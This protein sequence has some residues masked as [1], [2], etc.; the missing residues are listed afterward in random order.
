MVVLYVVART[1]R[2]VTVQKQLLLGRGYEP[3]LIRTEP[4]DR[5]RAG[6]PR[7]PIP[8]LS[9]RSRRNPWYHPAVLAAVDRYLSCDT[10]SKHKKLAI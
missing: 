8:Y 3:V 6:R 4:V 10:Q 1:L 5:E 9:L 2:G 7:I